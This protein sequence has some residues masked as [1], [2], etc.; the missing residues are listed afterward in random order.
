M[1]RK[2]AL[3]Q[4]DYA[5]L[6]IL[7]K[8]ATISNKELAEQIGL[9]PPATLVRVNHLKQKKYLLEASYDL[10]WSKLGF[11]SHIH[12]YCVIKRGNRDEFLK[13]IDSFPRIIASYELRKSD[14]F[15]VDVL[16]YRYILFGVFRD[17]YEWHKCWQEN[18]LATGIIEEFEALR[19][20]EIR[21]SKLPVP[22]FG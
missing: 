10:S 7:Q 14:E 18:I 5:I 9:S 8:D 17:Q 15:M 1:S 13:L 6:E 11:D 21:S 16:H 22:L 3:D 4:F 2:I 20:H 12:V 19:V